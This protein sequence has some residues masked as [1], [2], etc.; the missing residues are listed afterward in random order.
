MPHCR[1]GSTNDSSTAVSLKDSAII[2]GIDTIDFPES[3]KGRVSDTPNQRIFYR[4][5][6]QNL[7]K[8]NIQK[9]IQWCIQHN[10]MYNY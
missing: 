9:C 5:K 1:T 3:G 10:L 8:M 2:K 6:I 7:I 4:A